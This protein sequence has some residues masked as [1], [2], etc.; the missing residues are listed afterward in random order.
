MYAA[1]PGALADDIAEISAPFGS[2]ILHAG[3]MGLLSVDLHLRAV[4]LDQA[5]PTPLL[6]EAARQFRAYFDDGTFVFSLPLDLHGTAYQ[7]R[8]W[9]A[10]VEIPRGMPRSYGELAKAVGGGAR[11]VASACRSNPLPVLIPCHRVVGSHGPG[12]YCGQT[13]GP[14]LAVKQWLLQHERRVG[15]AGRS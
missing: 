7:R 4:A 13:S 6:K 2:V 8:V 14:W 9:Q 1:A 15:A 12:G 5:P 3:P 10:L 11:A